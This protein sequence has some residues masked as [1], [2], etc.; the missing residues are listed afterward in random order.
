MLQHQIVFKHFNVQNWPVWR[1]EIPKA[2]VLKNIPGT[3]QQSQKT[4]ECM[5]AVR[6]GT[7]FE[8]NW[9]FFSSLTQLPRPAATHKVSMDCNVVLMTLRGQS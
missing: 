9:K 1:L 2:E 7:V 8:W 4:G 5:E 6:F 3:F